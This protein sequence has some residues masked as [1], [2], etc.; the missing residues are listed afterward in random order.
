MQGGVWGTNQ[1]LAEIGSRAARKRHLD[2][3]KE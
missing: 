1:A 3:F 2:R